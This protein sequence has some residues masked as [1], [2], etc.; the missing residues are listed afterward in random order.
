[1][2]S[3]YKD[4]LTPEALDKMDIRN[5]TSFHVLTDMVE[6]LIRDT[7]SLYAR[8]VTKDAQKAIAKKLCQQGYRYSAIKSGLDRLAETSPNFPS[9]SDIV[10]SVRLFT[11][12][13]S[14]QTKNDAEYQKEQQRFEHYKAEMIKMIGEEG[15]SKYYKWWKKNV[16]PFPV[17]EEYQELYVK[18]AIFDWVDSGMS[19]N[20]EKITEIGKAKFK[21]LESLPIM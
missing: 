17:S 6:N 14:I 4:H 3:P 19:N 8:S 9:Y 10:A 1:M 5:P 11:P 21:R 12:Q 2:T 13:D 18:C 15:L 20:F 16:A 7:G